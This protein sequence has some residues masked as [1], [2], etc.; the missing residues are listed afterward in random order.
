MVSPLDILS[1]ETWMLL[2]TALLLLKFYIYRKWQVLK[3]L[4]IPHEPPS[5]LGLGNLASMFDNVDGIFNQD[6]I[7]KK[8]YGNVYGSYTGLQARIAVCDPEIIKQIYIKE[9]SNFRDRQITFSKVNGKYMNAALTAS[10]GDH[11]KRMRNSLT[12]AFSASKLKEMVR[13][14]EQ[15]VHHMTSALHK[16]VQ[17]D[18]GRF[19]VKETFGELSLDAVCSAAFS[20]N[21]HSN[22]PG[23]AATGRKVVEM[24][25]EIF[26]FEIFKN[27]LILIFMLF[28]WT[29]NIAEKLNYSIFPKKPITFFHRLTLS[30][31]DR[32]SHSSDQKRVDIMQ[33]ML[34]AEISEDEA[35]NGKAKGL[36]KQEITANAILMLIAGFETTANAL[37]YLTYNLATHKHVQEKLT[38]EIEETLKEYGELSYEALN[39]MKYLTMCLNESLRLY[40]VIARNSRYCENDITINGVQIPKG[41][42]VDIP[43]YGL[44]HDE[45]YWDE[46]F[47]FHP[48]RMEDMSKIDPMVFQPFGGGPRNC[49]GMRFAIMEIKMAICKTL[50]E[51]ELDVCE[52]TPIPPLQQ[53][54]KS[55][56]IPKERVFLKVVPREGIVNTE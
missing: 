50:K 30:L 15:C 24:S 10:R 45:E 4:N 17:N 23:A 39:S 42:H 38:E 44:S 22:S 48:E 36:T 33:S 8:Q 56:L 6:I 13:I 16:S 18:D 46:P 5:T 53:T 31:I 2:V 19:D 49:I 12:P 51:F 54:F 11:W 7:R 40:P 28:P 37:T 29:E 47:K 41:V 35:K 21:V 25:K 20:V 52:D 1:I 9:F 43:T 26:N 3:N 34:E 27:P 14:V 55:S 32:L